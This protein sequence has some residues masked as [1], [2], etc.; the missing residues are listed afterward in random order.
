M[1]ALLGLHA[2]AQP[3]EVG[4]GLG[5]LGDFFEDD[6]GAGEIA[7]FPAGFREDVGGA[8]VARAAVPAGLRLIGRDEVVLS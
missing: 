5:A 7:V 4:G 2:G 1:A 6:A 3:P 8:V